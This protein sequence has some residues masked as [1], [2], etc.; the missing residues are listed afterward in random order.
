MCDYHAAL[1]LDC[2]ASEYLPT[3]KR[4]G[5]ETEEGWMVGFSAYCPRDG[6]LHSLVCIPCAGMS[7]L[8][9]SRDAVGS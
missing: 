4:L 6:G 3:R 7:N 9:V 2:R 1:R 8:G 5:P